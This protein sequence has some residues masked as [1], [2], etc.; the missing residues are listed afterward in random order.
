MKAG[1]KKLL[2]LVTALLMASIPVKVNASRTDLYLKIEEPKDTP[3]DKKQSS[4]SVRSPGGSV[5]TVSGSDKVKNVKTGDTSAVFFLTAVCLSAG[6]G[7][8]M[9]VYR[10]INRCEKGR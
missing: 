8:C 7:I 9:M 2:F 1:R 5:R 4:S 6:A 10:R 3:T